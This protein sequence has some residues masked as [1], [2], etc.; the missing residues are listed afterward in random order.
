MNT[1]CDRELEKST[2]Q[3]LLGWAMASRVR[4]GETRSR[5]LPTFVLSALTPPAE[6]AEIQPNFAAN[7]ASLT[8]R[9]Q[10]VVA[11][12]LD[13]LR[14]NVVSEDVRAAA[15]QAWRGLVADARPER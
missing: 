9:Q 2:L 10:Q 7:I 4:S 11:R 5:M 13:W 15:V 1:P 14:R 3:G 8:P 12:A 6:G